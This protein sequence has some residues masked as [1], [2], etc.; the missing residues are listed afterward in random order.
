MH[1]A[2][3]PSQ[4]IYDS[5]TIKPSAFVLYVYFCLRRNTATGVCFP[6]LQTAARDLGMNYSYASTLRRELVKKG[7]IEMVENR[8]IRPIKGFD[9]PNKSIEIPNISTD[10]QCL[11]IPNKNIDIPNLN[12]EIPNKSLDIPNHNREVTDNLTD[13]G[14]DKGRT[15]TSKPRRAT[16]GR[17]WGDDEKVPEEWKAKLA[18]EFPNVD[19]EI[20]ARKFEN[21]WSSKS[22]ASATKKDWRKTFENWIISENQR[23]GKMAARTQPKTNKQKLEEY[24]RYF[25]ELEKKENLGRYL[26]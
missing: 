11:D 5:N 6:S 20:E 22:G 10:D 14:T 18:A 13:Q 12:I 7:W 3:V 17:R 25:D 23:A 2:K 1:F 8:L 4:A 16:T 9:I 21:F 19:V 24:E 26:E 15:R